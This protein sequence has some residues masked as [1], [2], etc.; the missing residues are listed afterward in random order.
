MV[1]MSLER[2]VRFSGIH[3]LFKQKLTESFSLPLCILISYRII[4]VLA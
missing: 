1:V 4:P 2:M 3:P